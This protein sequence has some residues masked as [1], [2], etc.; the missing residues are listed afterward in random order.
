MLGQD[1]CGQ[2]LE[3]R[4]KREVENMT[5]ASLSPA[6]VQEEFVK[7]MMMVGKNSTSAELSQFKKILDAGPDVNRLILRKGARHPAP[8]LKIAVLKENFPL[9]KLLLEYDVVVD[10]SVIELIF[11]RMTFYE[12]MVEEPAEIHKEMVVEIFSRASKFP[13]Y[14]PCWDLLEKFDL[15]RPLTHKYHVDTIKLLIDHGASFSFI[16]N[17]VSRHPLFQHL[18]YFRRIFTNAD[19][20]DRL[21]K[22]CRKLVSDEMLSSLHYGGVDLKKFGYQDFRQRILRQEEF[23]LNFFG[24]DVGGV[25]KAYI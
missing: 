9:F 14:H 24:R 17:D 7:L 25:V 16:V 21:D 23:I 22:R 19:Y 3:M 11:Y 1:C 18:V 12:E 8:P 2:H 13:V 4:K 20:W 6:E 15:S 5:T 10:D